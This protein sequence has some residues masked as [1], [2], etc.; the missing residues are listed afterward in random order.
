MAST[1]KTLREYQVR[2][3][4]DVCRASG[5]VL[6]EQPTG[7]GKTVQMVTLVAMH[8]GKRFTHAVISAPQQQIEQGFTIRD[9]N[10][11]AYPECQGVAVSP[12]QA[13]NDERMGLIR[14]SRD[15]G[16]GSVR[17][18]ATYL[19]QSLPPDHALACTHAALNQLTPKQLPNDLSGKAL[20]IDEA[21]HA[22]ADGLSQLVALW[23]EVLE[24][25]RVA[26]GLQLLE[27]IPFADGDDLGGLPV[28]GDRL[29]AG[30]EEVAGAGSFDRG[31]DK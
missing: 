7:S 22:S 29:P 19:R 12:I 1:T 21:H 9:Y 4:T 15:S 2:L 28:E 30:R 11:I 23:R 20:F 26:V 14:G 13:A 3:V 25:G 24:G 16:R 8:L 6:V 31:L 18:I 27:A 5:D 17:H 10:L